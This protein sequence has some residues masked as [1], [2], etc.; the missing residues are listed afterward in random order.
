M[1]LFYGDEGMFLVATEDS[2]IRYAE[3]NAFLEFILFLKKIKKYL[4]VFA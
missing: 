4:L 2:T 1:L 3:N